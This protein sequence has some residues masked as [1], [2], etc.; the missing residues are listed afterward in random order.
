MRRRLRWLAAA[1]L[2]LVLAAGAWLLQRDFAARRRAEQTRPIVDVLP[3]VA[4][5]IQNFHRVKIDNGRKVW[6]V[7]AREAQYL[8]SE[9]VV[10]VDAPVLQVFLQ[11]GRTVGLRG[12]GGKVFLKQRELQRV[13][14]QGDIDVQLDEYALHTET[15]QYEADRGVIVA[16]GEVR[17]SGKGL[18]MH[19]ARME[20]DVAAQR[21]ELSDRV[22]T[23][24]W[25]RS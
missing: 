2:V 16:P 17:I 23:T 7:S 18:E 21:L 3:N 20:I 11:D 13:E 9:E 10:V 1:L 4:Q 6:E 15:A 12:D 19:G 25:P 5:R 22:Q 14:L 24:M 8:E